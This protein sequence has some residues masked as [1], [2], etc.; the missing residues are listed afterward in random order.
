MRMGL[1]PLQGKQIPFSKSVLYLASIHDPLFRV[2]Q[3]RARMASRGGRSKGHW[4]FYPPHR[5]SRWF[6]VAQVIIPS[7]AAVMGIAFT[8]VGISKAREED[9]RNKAR[10]DELVA[11]LEEGRKNR[12]LWERGEIAAPRF[13]YGTFYPNF[14]SCLHVLI[15]IKFSDGRGGTTR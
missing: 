12:E 3:S 10:V 8:V 6:Q 2:I 11:I 14:R 13:F 1:V 5:G 7:S 4:F 15:S 9:K